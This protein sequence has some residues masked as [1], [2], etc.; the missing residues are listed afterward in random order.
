MKVVNG[1]VEKCSDTVTFNNVKTTDYYAS[2][3]VKKLTEPALQPGDPNYVW[4]F[5]LFKA[6]ALVGFASADAGG[7]DVAAA[8][9]GLDALIRSWPAADHDGRAR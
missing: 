5:Q 1:K 7:T 8:A 4:T 6:G 3:Q 2:A 9:S